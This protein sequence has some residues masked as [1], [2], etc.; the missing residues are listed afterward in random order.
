MERLQGLLFQCTKHMLVK[1][2]R[3]DVPMA[4]EDDGPCLLRRGSNRMASSCLSP[5]LVPSKT[6]SE[7]NFAQCSPSLEATAPIGPM[8]PFASRSKFH[9]PFHGDKQ[10]RREHYNRRERGRHGVTQPLLLKHTHLSSLAL[11]SR[12]VR[13]HELRDAQVSSSRVVRA[14]YQLD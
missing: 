13:L 8:Q 6:S 10:A 2:R 4:G 1:K 7:R 14:L 12:Q 11:G 9:H 5:Q 3:Q